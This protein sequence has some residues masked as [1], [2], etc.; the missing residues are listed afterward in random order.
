MVVGFFSF[1]LILVAML[2]GCMNPLQENPNVD[3]T[4]TTLQGQTKQLREYYGT[5]VVL[6]LMGV[7][8]QPCALEM[9][10][11]KQIQ[12]NYSRNNVIIISVDVW[13]SQGENASLLRQ[14][15]DAFHQQLHLELNWTFG[16]DDTKGTIGN[17]YARS[18]I[19]TLYILDKKGNI[20]Y[21]HVGYDSYSR[22]ASKLDAVLT[23]A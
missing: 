20:Y 17:T 12:T 9:R 13:I 1:F 2:P 21:T 14:Y 19:P 4:F 23:K 11:L 18:G 6:D 22:L 3:F 8:C 16:L 7:N 10:Q 15:L 5:V